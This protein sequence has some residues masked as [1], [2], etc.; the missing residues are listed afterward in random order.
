MSRI[1]DRVYSDAADIA[2]LEAIALQLPQDLRV[3]VTLD[4]GTQLRGVVT[5]TPT[6]QMFFDPQ[7]NEGLNALARIEGS[8]DK[9]QPG[10]GGDHY[11]W[12]DRIRAVTQLPNP[13][14]PEPTCRVSPTDPNA[15]T[16]E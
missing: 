13:S 2:R 6:M 4:D 1:A 15:P 16:V 7:G 11:V 8:L 9:R 5:A 12:L 3:A 10:G 14:P